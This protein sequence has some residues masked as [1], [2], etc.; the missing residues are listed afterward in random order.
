MATLGNPHLE[1]E[2]LLAYELGYRVEP[3]KRCSFDL[4]GFYNQY[5]RLIEAV[6]GTP[7]F[8]AGPPLPYF[9]VPSTT[10]N[11]GPAQTYGLELSG[12]WDVC[13]CWKL[14][15]SWTWFEAHTPEASV[16]L[17]SSPEQQFQ[18]R[19]VL[20]LPGNLQFNAAV[21][22]VDQIQSPYGTG[23]M[24]IPSYVD[25]D[26]GLV[27]HPWK[28]LELGI[29]GQNLVDGRHAEFTSYKTSLITDVPRGVMGKITWRF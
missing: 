24:T 29:W 22:Y 19:S 10:E 27:W 26:L 12:R 6:P 11:V 4:A 5:N 7:Q 8:E 20:S 13:D 28:S 9:L 3:T 16:S 21:Y 15:A 25:L 17:G 2:E 18:V 23:Q 1:S 14:A